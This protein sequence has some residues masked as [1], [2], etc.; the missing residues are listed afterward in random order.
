VIKIDKKT[1]LL[2]SIFSKLTPAKNTID[3]IP[4]GSGIMDKASND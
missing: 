4:A 1:M 2:D 3:D